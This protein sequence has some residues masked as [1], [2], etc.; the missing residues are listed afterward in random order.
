MRCMAL[1]EFLMESG[2]EPVFAMRDTSDLVRD[3]LHVRGLRRVALDGADSARFGESDDAR[4]T[5]DACNR[6]GDVRVV[7]VDSYALGQDWCVRVR[8]SGRRV[9]VIDDLH[10]RDI[11][12]DLVLNTA[13]HVG[14]SAYAG[15]VPRETMLL[16]GCRFALLRR[17]FEGLR[18][19]AHDVDHASDRVLV[20]YGGGDAEAMT[21]AT[22]DVLSRHPKRPDR[23]DV[24]GASREC[25]VP[26]DTSVAVHRH[27]P[28][29]GLAAVAATCTAAFGAA[30]VSAIER[31]YLGLPAACACLAE[32]QRPSLDWLASHS[33]VHR[34][35]PFDADAIAGAADALLRGASRGW[36]AAADA[37]RLF[38]D[39]TFP[40]RRVAAA[41]QEL[42]HT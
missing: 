42:T 14:E 18:G 12:A 34:L 13:P 29:H 35:D 7:V 22:I 24:I 30:G 16:L 17:E 20:S 31:L 41:I 8:A 27:G 2:S 39:A 21:A 26:V 1:A 23:I 36:F 33:M 11:E 3:A 6:V 25:V 5:V 40:T 32:N 19:V 38:G 9:V 37:D 28:S 15:R 10:D 4:A